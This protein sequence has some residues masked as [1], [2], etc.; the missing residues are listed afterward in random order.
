[1]SL[2][3]RLPA[4]F[5][6][7]IFGLAAWPLGPDVARSQVSD[8]SN[9]V[10]AVFAALVAASGRAHGE[11]E[12]RV[13]AIYREHFD[14]A[15][16]A[17]IILGRSLHLAAGTNR[18]ELLDLLEDHVVKAIAARLPDFAGTAIDTSFSVPEGDGV[19]VYSRAAGLGR[20]RHAD[21]R[22]RLVKSGNGFRV[23][24]VFVEG[25]SLALVEKREIAGAAARHGGGADGLARALRER[26]R[27]AE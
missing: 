23:R 6:A 4:F 21:L 18:S 11:G 8:G 1:M 10:R 20:I 24:D 12:E 2:V 14:H 15:A 13:R 27:R 16:I 17:A 3:R 7:A 19:V 9:T 22:W 26:N 5:A 25:L